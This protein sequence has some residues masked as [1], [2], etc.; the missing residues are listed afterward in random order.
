VTPAIPGSSSTLT[1]CDDVARVRR[2]AAAMVMVSL[3][4]ACSG[5]E[6]S[7]VTTAS[8]TTPPATTEAQA[9]ITAESLPE[10]ALP[11]EELPRGFEV[12]REGYVRTQDPVVAAYRR[13]FDSGGEPLGDSTVDLVSTDVLLFESERDAA[14]GLGA[15]VAALTGDDVQAQFE[16]LVESN[17]GIEASR[18]RGQTL[19]TTT[20]ADGAVV[21]RAS[22]RSE[23]GPRAAIFLV[24]RVGRLHGG[25]LVL[26]PRGKLRLED[27]GRALELVIARLQAA[28]G[29]RA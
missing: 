20:L 24:A 2:A 12:S 15:L 18:V 28:S 29:P 27:A 21:A 8:S 4:A 25:V 11:A 26:G 10:L 23:D 14:G 19:A 5:G 6:D 9:A 7:N 17:T 3:A 22:F 16:E 1:A 13:A